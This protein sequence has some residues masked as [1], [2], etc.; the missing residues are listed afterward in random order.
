MQ[1]TAPREVVPDGPLLAPSDQRLPPLLERAQVKAFRNG[2]DRTV[3]PEQ[4]VARMRPLLPA[5]GITRLADV[6]GLDVVG[7]P[8]V[9][10]VR[11]LSRN[12]VVSQGKGL[13]LAAAQASAIMECSEM[14]HAQRHV[15]PLRW[16]SVDEVAATAPVADVDRMLLWDEQGSP[17]GRQFW[18][19]PS[20]D[21]LGG[22]RR[23]VPYEAVHCDGRLPK[24]SGEDLFVRG[25]NG[26]ASGNS[27]LEAVLHA[28][29]EL[30]ERDQIADWEALGVP[31]QAG[32]R[33]DPATV[34]E[35]GCRDL[36]ARFAAA[37][38]EPMLFDL[39]FGFGL[40]TFTCVLRQPPGQLGTPRTYGQGWGTHCMPEIALA[41]ALTE[42]A[43]YRCTIIS[44]AR[45]DYSRESF[46]EVFYNSEVLGRGDVLAAESTALRDFACVRGP[47]HPT[48]NEDL[49]HVLSALRAGGITEVDVVDY[50]DPD[51]DVA[52]AKVVVPGL[53]D[54]ME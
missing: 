15:H 44:G 13:T 30:V 16:G 51:L 29:Y 39:T 8:T 6:T 52:V 19:V 28:L 38:I 11:P 2:T 53:R 54:G 35:P 49:E 14:W 5:M 21:L 50:T 4:T 36:I 27:A 9:C 23:W 41:R 34:L 48:L 17:H 46:A 37:G 45:D 7:I 20:Y 12:L 32:R 1:T 42:A 26:L 33:I 43:Q 47:S 25:S 22:T 31:E 40:P 10:A 3:P 18:W 24:A